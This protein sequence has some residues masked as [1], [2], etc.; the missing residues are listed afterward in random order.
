M[1]KSSAVV[2]GAIDVE[3]VV[4]KKDHTHSVKV[5]DETDNDFQ[6]IISHLKLMVDN[7]HERMLRGDDGM[8]T[9]VCNE[10]SHDITSFSD[11][12]VFMLYTRHL[13]CVLKALRDGPTPIVDEDSGAGGSTTL[14]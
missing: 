13:T 11:D 2:P 8:K 3:S 10:P 4:I 1:S 9:G 5:R 6:N 14:R 7:A 12:D